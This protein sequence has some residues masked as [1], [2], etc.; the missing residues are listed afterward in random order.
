MRATVDTVFALYADNRSSRGD[1]TSKRGV[2]G[3]M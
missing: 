2:I 3:Y 1:L